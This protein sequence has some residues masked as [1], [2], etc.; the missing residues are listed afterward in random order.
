MLKRISI[1][2]LL[3]LS[4]VLLSCFETGDLKLV[5]NDISEDYLKNE[6]KGN[7]MQCHEFPKDFLKFFI[8]EAK[9]SVNEDPDT[10][11]AEKKVLLNRLKAFDLYEENRLYLA[12]LGNNETKVGYRNQEPLLKSKLNL[13]FSIVTSNNSMLI[14]DVIPYI[15]SE[16]ITHTRRDNSASIN[17]NSER[18]NIEKT[19]TYYWFIKTKL[20]INEKYLKDTD[21]PVNLIVKFPNGKT[22]T[23]LIL[24]KKSK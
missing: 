16:V 3:V 17:I 24:D 6:Y 2:V 15:R 19:F 5:K 22:Q 8:D 23:Y 10:S 7:T 21:K 11:D 1:L 18:T 12:I 4:S 9:L 13:N 14:E 20:P